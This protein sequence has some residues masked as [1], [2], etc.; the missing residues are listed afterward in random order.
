MI[1]FFICSLT[2]M[3]IQELFAHKT[4]VAPK[5]NLSFSEL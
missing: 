5:K 1:G 3:L 2:L 4:L